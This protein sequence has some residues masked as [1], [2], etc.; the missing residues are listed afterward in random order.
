MSHGHQDTE[1]EVE[2]I[3]NHECNAM[4]LF[5]QIQWTGYSE[6]WRTWEPS[7]NCAGCQA[8]I[9]DYWD[10]LEEMCASK[11]STDE[12]GELKTKVKTS[13]RETLR[14]RY[15]NSLRGRIDLRLSSTRKSM[16]DRTPMIIKSRQ[17]I[18]YEPTS[19]CSSVSRISRSWAMTIIA[20][21]SGSHFYLARL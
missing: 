16:A 7:T 18:D 10:E 19:A 1:F 21:R 20:I 3:T 2:R 5:Y 9:S 6:H 14:K 8:A 12:T 4:G 11:T 17:R 13:L 15:S